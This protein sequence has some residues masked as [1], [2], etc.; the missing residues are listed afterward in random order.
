MV[1]AEIDCDGNDGEDD[2]G[3]ANVW[4]ILR[5]VIVYEVFSSYRVRID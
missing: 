4:A 3:G 5:E 2:D 1:N